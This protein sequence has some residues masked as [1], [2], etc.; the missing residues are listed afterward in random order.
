M[1]DEEKIYIP[2]NVKA[3]SYFF[4][5]FGTAELIKAIITTLVV[6]VIWL[7]VYIINKNLPFLILAEMVTIAACVMIYMKDQTNQSVVDYAKNM[8]VFSKSKKIYLFNN[9]QSVREFEKELIKTYGG[10]EE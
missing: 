3:E 9:E 1:K 10:E 4:D 8:I 5:G 2:S 6:S 7:I